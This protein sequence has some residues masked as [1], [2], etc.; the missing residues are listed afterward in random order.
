MP[1][2][3]PWHFFVN[4]VLFSP[5]P[6]TESVQTIGP[7]LR[8]APLWW[9]TLPPICDSRAACVWASETWMM[10]MNLSTIS[11]L[12]QRFFLC[13]WFIT[14]ILAYT[15]AQFSF[16]VCGRRQLPLQLQLCSIHAH[17]KH[18]ALKTVLRKGFLKFWFTP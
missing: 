14:P 12:L 18:P 5:L 6:P 16:Q 11:W 17:V 1:L 15:R 4:G 10:V 8:L 13:Q 2:K 7:W 9:N 3:P